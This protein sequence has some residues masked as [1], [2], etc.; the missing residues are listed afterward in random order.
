MNENTKAMEVAE[1]TVEYIRDDEHALLHV[2]E[3]IT[4]YYDQEKKHLKEI[5]LIVDEQLSGNHRGFYISGSIKFRHHYTRGIRNGNFYDY[6]ENGKVATRL[7][8]R[9]GE[10][11]PAPAEKVI[12]NRVINKYSVQEIL[13][14][15]K[16]AKK[17][18][19]YLPGGFKVHTNSARLR[20]F[21][22]SQV[23]VACGIKATHFQL[24]WPVG[25]G[26]PHLNMYAINKR[27]KT[28]LMTRD[29]IEPKSLGG[30][31]RLVNSQVMCSKCNSLKGNKRD[32]ELP[33][34]FWKVKA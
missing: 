24:E 5:R 25:Q 18:H 11:A 27:G 12:T 30:T 16:Q 15:L 31:D 17:P 8:Y 1:R 10:L 6:D 21:R 29:H 7:F 4:E 28:I 14:W 22:Q 34:H 19:D 13:S 23:C 32:H 9:N 26:I 3:H 2:L 33:K 20:L